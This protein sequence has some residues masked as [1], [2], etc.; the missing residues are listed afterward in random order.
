DPT[1]LITDTATRAALQP[2]I[3]ALPHPLPVL[4]LH[5]DAATWADAPTTDPDPGDVGLSRQHLAYV[6]Y[7]SGSTGQPKAVLVE[8]GQLAAIAA[9]WERSLELRPGLA[10]LQMAGFSFDV[11]TADVVRALGFGGRLV[12]C[13]SELLLDGAGL[14]DLMRRSRIGFADFV[15]AVLNGLLDHWQGTG[16]DLPELRT[17]VCGSDVWTAASAARLRELCGPQVRIVHAYGV[18]EACVDSTHFTVPA[19]GLERLDS[20]P[21]GRPLPGVR[22]HLLDEAGQP[23][24]DGLAG[25]IHIGGAGVARGYLNRP[26]LTAERFLASPFDEGERLYRT[27]D[28]GRWLPS[29]ELEFLGREDHQV[30]VRGFRIELGEIE[31]RLAACP[32]VRDAVVTARQLAGDDRQLVAYYRTDDSQQVSA[33]AAR[34]WLA[35]TLP[36]H[37]TPAAFVRLAAWPLTPNGKIDRAALPA[38]DAQA[39]GQDEYAEPAGPLESEL[40]AIFA[41]LLSPRRI[42]RHDDFFALGGHSLLATRVVS[43]IRERLD[44]EVP[45]TALFAAPTVAALAEWL[46]SAERLTRRQGLPAGQQVLPPITGADR[47]R[48]LDAS[49]AQQRLWF[50]AQLEGGSEAYHVVEAFSL[51]G[52]LDRAALAGALDALTARHEVLRTRLVSVAGALTQLVDPPSVGF[53][54][55][56]EDLSGQADAEAELDR[57]RRAEAAA[58]FDLAHGPLAR[59]RLVV[60]GPDRH[61]LLLTLHHVMSDGWSMDVLARELGALYTALRDGRPDPLPPLPVQYADYAAWQRGWLTGEVLAGQSEF[62]KQALDGAPALLELPTD[63]PRP[64]EQD[65]RGDQL[66]V[67]LDAELTAALHAL[68]RRAGCTLFMTVL[69]GLAL[70]LSRLSGQDEVVIGTPTANR[71]LTELEGLIG[72]FVNTLPLRVDLAGDPTGAELLERVRAVTLAALEHQD[73]PFEQLVELVNPTRSLAHAPVFQVLFAWQNNENAE[74]EL[75]G[76][77]VRALGPASSVAKYDLTLSLGESDGRIVGVLEYASGLFGVESADRIAGYL[78]HALAQ[79]AERPAQPAATLPLVGATERL[80]L[81]QDWNQ[82]RQPVRSGIA[83][84]FA[85]QVAAHPDAIAVE[86]STDQLT[87]AQLNTAANQLAHHLRALGVTA[88]TR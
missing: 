84:R 16:E 5:A 18:T 36:A 45:A 27:G 32:G 15:P 30:K 52:P 14:F 72:F 55:R 66:R 68:S 38:P 77:E 41:E 70:V 35:H 1:L 83:E 7:T 47:T 46:T 39:Y 6:I 78:R 10:H 21:I 62:W 42:G 75:P 82:T 80:R 19:G 60:L 26:E 51:D 85:A 22:I 2:A 81:V 69:A 37:M 4:D 25:E 12:L 11:F 44:R 33:G 73:L 59:G 40:A 31:A 9:A 79:L 34:Q 86:S 67:E 53:R 87:Y 23:V 50:L 57:I 49:F 13:P 58:P 61:V 56:T 29:G 28:L 17:V 88:D 54:L 71:R 8:H 43:K 65:Y 48:P 74:L 20:L 76:V 24:A 64:A 3:A 63:A